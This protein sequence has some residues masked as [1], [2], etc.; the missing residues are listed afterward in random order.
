MQKREACDDAVFMRL[1]YTIP[2][3]PG[4][5]ACDIYDICDDGVSQAPIYITTVY[6]EAC[7]VYMKMKVQAWVAE[8]NCLLTL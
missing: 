4:C 5:V 7:F 8:S 1:C 3:I 6:S 2:Q